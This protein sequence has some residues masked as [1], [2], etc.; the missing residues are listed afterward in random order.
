MVDTC[1]EIAYTCST[2]KKAVEQ[3]SGRVATEKITNS[4]SHRTDRLTEDAKYREGSLGDSLNPVERICRGFE[5]L[6]QIPKT[7]GHVE[8]ATR[9]HW[10][11]YRV[12]CVSDTTHDACQI[13]KRLRQSLDEDRSAIQ[14]RPALKKGI[15]CFG[16]LVDEPTKDF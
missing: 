2:L 14:T 7:L 12:E 9:S 13:I 11:K 4:A 15:S 1:E 16:L 10:R 8:Q 6:H 3:P 5:I